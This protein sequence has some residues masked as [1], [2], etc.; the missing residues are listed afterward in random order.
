MAWAQYRSRIL[1]CHDPCS[2]I[3]DVFAGPP[4]IPQ[5]SSSRLAEHTVDRCRR[6]DNYVQCAYFFFDL[7][8]EDGWEPLEFFQ[9]DPTF[10]WNDGGFVANAPVDIAATLDGAIQRSTSVESAFRWQGR[11]V[12]PNFTVPKRHYNHPVLTIVNGGQ[13]TVEYGKD[14]IVETREIGPGEFWT[15]DPLVPFTVASGPE[16]VT[17]LECW[18]LQPRCPSSRP[19][20]TTTATGSGAIRGRPSALGESQVPILPIGYLRLEATDIEAWETFA[21]DFLGMMPE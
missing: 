4:A 18:D 7:L 9:G 13:M 15:G 16:G 1:F 5:V 17:Y 3:R 12:R 19:R 14:S 11:R 8:A 20:G 6:P 2:V 21:G 10:Y